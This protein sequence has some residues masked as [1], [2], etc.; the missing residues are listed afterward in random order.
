MA[1]FTVNV[2]FFAFTMHFNVDGN[3]GLG[4][5]RP[6]YMRQKNLKTRRF[7]SENT[8]NVSVHTAPEELENAAITGDFGFVFME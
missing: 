7:N 5:V 3:S 1:R 8:S 6:H 2:S 4:L